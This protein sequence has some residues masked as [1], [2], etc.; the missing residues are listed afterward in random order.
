[1]G[2]LDG[3]IA[4]ISGGDRG[5]GLL[6]AKEFVK[7]GAYVFITGGSHSQL[8]AAVK[9]IE[10]KELHRTRVGRNVTGVQGEVSN[11]GDLDRVFAQIEREKGKLDVVFAATNETMSDNLT[12]REND[13]SFDIYVNGVFATVEKAIPLLGDGA[14]VI[15]LSVSAKETTSR[16]D[17][18]GGSAIRSFWRTWIKELRDRGIRVNAVNPG[19]ISTG[20][21]NGLRMSGE[22]SGR[23]LISDRPWRSS[24]SL[25][26]EVAE[27]VVFLASDESAHIEGKDLMVGGNSLSDHVPLG[28][29]GTP[30]E[31]AKAVAFLASN[32]SRG[33]TGKELFV[34]VGFSE[35]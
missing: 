27:A 21:L 2:K 33:I 18:V 28:R 14:C 22:R 19:P 11:A 4:L 12:E 3:R 23:M 17:S 24:L 7:E 20:Q 16:N 6:T 9:E 29:L 10:A 1:M 30:E 34:G 8:A 26:E 5:I 13:W 25:V 35:L 32:D 31:V 15:L